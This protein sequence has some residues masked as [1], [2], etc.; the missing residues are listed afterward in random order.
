M[1]EINCRE[2]L[3][4]IYLLLDGELSPETCEELQ[5]HLERCRYCYGRAETERLFKELVRDR[6]GCEQAPPELVTRIRFAIAVEA[7]E[8]E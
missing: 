6:C 5:V 3:E 2:V 4:K 7:S 8:S 1:S